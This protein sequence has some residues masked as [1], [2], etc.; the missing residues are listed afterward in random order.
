MKRIT[1]LLS[2]LLCFA[3]AARADK[4][5]ALVQTVHGK[6]LDAES[7]QGIP[8]VIV[9][10][11]ADNNRNAMTDSAGYFELTGVPV[12]RQSFRFILTGYETRLLPEVMITS[13]KMAEL[14]VSMKETVQ[15]L[16]EVS[17]TASRNNLNGKNEFAGVSSRGFNM[18][19]TK[20]Y[21]AAIADPA[22]MA[23]NFPG[24]SGSNDMNNGIV[25]RGN[26]PRG[27]SYRLEGV[28]IPNPN[29]YS[30]LGGSAGAIS[31]LNANA[32]AQSDFYTAAFP[33]EIGNSLSGVFD[34]KLR[35]GNTARAE[36]S[37]QI[38]TTGFEF[39]TEGAFVTGGKA[40][41]LFNYRYSNP[42]LL[43][44]FLDLKGIVPNYQDLSFK[45][46]F[47]TAKLGTF[48]VFGVGGINN[49]KKDPA[50]DTSKLTDGEIGYGMRNKA[51]TG[52]AGISHQYQLPRGYI[53]SVVAVSREISEQGVDTGIAAL[54]NLVLPLKRSRL[55]QHTLS[56]GTTYQTKINANN[57]FRTGISMQHTD[58][59]LDEKLFQID[60]LGWRMLV[61]DDGHTSF[62]QGYAQWKHR[63]SDR[64][65]IIGGMHFSHFSFTNR[66]SAEPR[67][68]ASYYAGKHTFSLAAG[69]HSKPEHIATYQLKKVYKESTVIY[70]NKKLDMTRA[71]HAVAGYEVSLPYKMRLKAEAYYQ[72]L[73]RVAV[74]ADSNSGFSMLNVENLTAVTETRDLVSDGT[75][76]NY[77]LD[78]SLEKPFSNNYYFLLTGSLFR[79]EYTNYAG[80]TFS[81]RYDRRFQSNLVAGKEFNL[82]N[83]RRI[84]GVNLKLVY[85]GGL[86]ESP[87]DVE[88]SK[89]SGKTEYIRDQYFTKSGP[90][91]FRTDASVY[92]KINNRQATHT[93]Q[94]DVQ[95]LSDHRNHY[96]S[97]FDPKSGQVKAV[98]QLGIIPS[99]SYRIDFR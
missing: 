33:A 66:F 16:K 78:L 2:I 60:P 37:V 10:L 4:N 85:S 80:K 46:H 73:Y 96:Y 38:G 99:I 93:L 63:A 45:L 11:D 57:T 52:I 91:Y 87:V 19:E 89:A 88:R 54:N 82:A 39:A 84:A 95:N 49:A 48:S 17:V 90:A 71:L 5:P 81:T 22:R 29:H 47:P 72:H 6:V 53:R 18:E 13:G 28:D 20:R 55:E 7:S 44:R 98:D 83:N 77:G 25:V 31:M 74:E 12:G 15:Q 30:K 50:A 41:Y 64:L 58:Y 42:A 70:P 34:L 65:T 21:A 97:Y 69:M 56:A 68:S 36:H 43:R 9:V 92:Y 86:K 1:L 23:S 79:S 8:G 67:L 59:R 51:Y 94:L 14:N 3:A 62:Y 75:G 76:R 26:S 61:D 35:T 32:L 40:S 24:V 27:V